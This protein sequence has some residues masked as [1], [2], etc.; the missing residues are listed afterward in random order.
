MYQ[1][2]YRFSA[3]PRL[4]FAQL[5]GMAQVAIEAVGAVPVGL[6]GAPHFL[7]LSYMETSRMLAPKIA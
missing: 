7:R 6:V 2:E 4:G 5:E 1:F 3:Q